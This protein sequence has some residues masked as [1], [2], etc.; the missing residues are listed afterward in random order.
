VR[1]EIRDNVYKVLNLSLSM[2]D[3]ENECIFCKIARKEVPSEIILETRNF[4]AVP[5]IR[6]RVKGHTLIITKKHYSTLIDMPESL[7]SELLDVVKKLFEKKAKEEGAEGFNLVVNNFPAAGQ[8]IHHVHFHLLPRK[9]R[10][11]KKMD[12]WDVKA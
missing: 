6:P 3:K 1:A 11:G 10:D 9:S 8:I 12:L 4:I 2:A 5:D 7:G